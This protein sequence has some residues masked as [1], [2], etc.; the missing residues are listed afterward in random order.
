MAI[1]LRA[2]DVSDILGRELKVSMLQAAE[3]IL[4]KALKDIE[5]QMREK[6]AS[7]LISFIENDFVVERMGH[8]IRIVVKQAHKEAKP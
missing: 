1:V 7:R 5:Q 6:M 3:P 4:Q 8:D 2:E